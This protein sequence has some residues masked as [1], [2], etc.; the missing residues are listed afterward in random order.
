MGYLLALGYD[1]GEVQQTGSN[2]GTKHKHDTPY[3]TTIGTGSMVSDGLS[4]I[5]TDYST[6]SFRVTSVALGARSFLGNVI[7]Y[8]S[9]AKLGDNCLLA[10]KVMVPIDG[11]IRENVG[12]LG[13]PSFEIPR[14]VQ[15][16]S[17]F[18]HHKRGEELDRRLAAKNA[19]NTVSIALYLLMHWF[20]A[21][22]VT[23]LGLFA[24]GLYADFGATA[25]AAAT[26]LATLFMR[27][28]SHWSNA[29]ST[30][31]SA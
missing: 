17:L 27:S 28:T 7:A 10:T 9:Q 19:Y 29:P 5:N 13:S 21:L 24:V 12:L 31:S 6:T 11:A 1:L 14:S 26:V 8:P 4:I 18:D 16:D 20:H 22:I 25:I 2:F 3:L 23:L 30:R 15:R